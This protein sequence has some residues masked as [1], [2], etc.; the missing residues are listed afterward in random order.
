MP[1]NTEEVMARTSLCAAK[2]EPSARQNLLFKQLLTDVTFEGIDD[3]FSPDVAPLL[4]DIELADHVRKKALGLSP[5]LPPGF[6]MSNEIGEL[7]TLKDTPPILN[8]FAS[9]G[10]TPAKKNTSWPI[11]P[12]YSIH[13]P[14]KSS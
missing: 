1:L 13:I 6:S 14:K 3:F 7:I 4:L 9:R 8:R 2:T 11:S 5:I 12:L 10:Q